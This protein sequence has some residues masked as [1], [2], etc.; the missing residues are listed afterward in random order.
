M[1][2]CSIKEGPVKIMHQHIKGVP[3]WVHTGFSDQEATASNTKPTSHPDETLK[4]TS[5]PSTSNGTGRGR[6][7]RIHH[8]AQKT[9]RVDVGRAG[10]TA[11]LGLSGLRNPLGA[12][13]PAWNQKSR[14]HHLPNAIHSRGSNALETPDLYAAVQTNLANLGAIED[15]FMSKAQ[16]LLALIK[17]GNQKANR[18]TH[19]TA[20]KEACGCRQRL[21]RLLRRHVQNAGI[22]EE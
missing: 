13:E 3:F 15:L 19:G 17:S 2:I 6:S 21:R 1:D 10:A 11:F 16:E 18:G 7:P 22:K 20:Q 12:E 8:D 14:R 4:N 9:R 5:L